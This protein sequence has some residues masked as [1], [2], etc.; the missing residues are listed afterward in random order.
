[1]LLD[2]INRKITNLLVRQ[3]KLSTE[4]IVKQMFGQV[5]MISKSYLDPNLR[6][7]TKGTNQAIS[8]LLSLK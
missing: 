6:K 3:M 5:L 8:F 2:R 1:M 4:E 7:S